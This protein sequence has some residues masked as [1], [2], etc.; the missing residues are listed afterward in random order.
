MS[1]LLSIIIPGYSVCVSICDDNEVKA[2]QIEYQEINAF[3]YFYNGEYTN[4]LLR[5]KKTG[6]Q[7]KFLSVTNGKTIS[8]RFKKN[9]L[10]PINEQYENSSDQQIFKTEFEWL[11]HENAEN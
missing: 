11:M 8:S 1:D 4:S 3:V 7:C 9:A 6:N 10:I 2:F 5:N